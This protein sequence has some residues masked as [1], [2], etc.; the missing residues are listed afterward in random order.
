MRQWKAD[1]MDGLFVAE[2]AEIIKAI[3]L[4]CVRM[5]DVLFWPY[6]SNRVYSYKSGYRFLKEEAK[7]E[8]TS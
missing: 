2:D 8:V 1:F 4:S 3:P 5:E 7:M 6:T